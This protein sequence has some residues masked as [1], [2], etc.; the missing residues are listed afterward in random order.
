[1]GKSCLSWDMLAVHPCLE[2]LLILF[3]NEG[4]EKARKIGRRLVVKQLFH[5]FIYAW[6]VVFVDLMALPRLQAI[7]P[8]LK[9]TKHLGKLWMSNGLSTVIG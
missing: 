2:N 9:L 5:V 6:E 1:M 4:S 8:I 3:L 7:L